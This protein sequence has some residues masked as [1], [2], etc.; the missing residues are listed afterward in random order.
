MKREIFCLAGF[1]CGLIGFLGIMAL[2]FF[3]FL[4][5][6][7]H[8]LQHLFWVMLLSGCL[9]AVGLAAYCL[10]CDCKKLRK[11]CKP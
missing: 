9:V 10:A 3:G 5:Y 7:L 1:Y 4:V 11:D 8:L 6:R 2:I